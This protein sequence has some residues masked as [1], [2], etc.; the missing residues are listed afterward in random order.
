MD[1][2]TILFL[3]FDDPDEYS[4]AFD[5]SQSSTYGTLSGGATFTRDAHKGKA[6]SLNGSGVC[7][8]QGDIPFDSDFTITF[9]IKPSTDVLTWLLNYSGTNNY[10]EQ[11][12]TVSPDVWM[13]MAFVKRPGSFMV[14]RDG[15][16]IYSKV[17]STI[18]K[19]DDPMQPDTEIINTPIGLSVNDSKLDTGSYACIDE[20][21][22]DDVART[23]SEIMKIQQD[24]SDV[25]YYVDGKNFK[26]YGVYVSKSTGVVGGLAKKDALSVDY[27]NYHGLVV[28]KSRPRYKERT[29]TLEC[30]IQASG[31]S[32]FVEM[33][34]Y[35]M[36]QFDKAG[37]RR[38]KV[39]YDGETRPLLFEVDR[40]A[41]A[42]IDK[43]WNDELM[44]GTFNMKLRECEPVK[45]I[46]RHI[47]S[48]TATIKVTTAKMLNIAWGDNSHTYDVSGT[49]K[50]VTH[51]YDVSGTYDIV[52]SG[53]IED[54]TSFDTNCIIIWNRLQ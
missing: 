22:I 47:G 50:T 52:I 20:F 53:V 37:D 9:W 10:L 43:T 49:D 16:L 11:V 2:D 34:N 19:S 28:D 45:R 30:F 42:D 3:P 27:D 41:E 23:Q 6:L 51:T 35:F 31:R 36:S 25:E 46:L 48:G 32:N 29:I 15:E 38:L 1:K 5:Y 14:Y 13:F 21:R 4:K 54:I 18:K 7:D 12:L 33:A 17:T 26:D 8:V 40:A 24:D 44:V 39:E